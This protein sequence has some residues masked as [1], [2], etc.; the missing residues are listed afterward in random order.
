MEK[1][2]NI[3]VVLFPAVFLLVFLIWGLLKPDA[4]ISQSERRKL[5]QK[6]ELTAV[7]VWSAACPDRDRSSRAEGQPRDLSRG[8]LC[9]QARLPAE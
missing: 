2:K 9:G 1:R 3:A 7:S 6:P 5:A 8:R 4:D